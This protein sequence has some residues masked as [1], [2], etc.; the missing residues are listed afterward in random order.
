MR[1]ERCRR[2]KETAYAARVNYKPKPLGQTVPRSHRATTAVKSFR[3][4]SRLLLCLF[5]L[6]VALPCAVLAQTAA[7]APRTPEA[8]EALN[9][10]VTAAQQQD[11]MLAI[12]Y[13]QDARAI[14]PRDPLIILNLGL[15]ESKIPGRELRAIAWFG[16]Y[17]SA[18]PNASN[19]ATVTDQIGRLDAKN[20]SNLSR[21]IS[22]AQDAATSLSGSPQSEMLYKVAD[23]WAE[24]G[25]S[26]AALKTVDLMQD[27]R[28]KSPTEYRIAEIQVEDSDLA[29]A[30]KTADLIPDAR[31]K[32]AA[33]AAIA[34]AQAKA[35]DIAGARSTLAA[36]LQTADSIRALPNIGLPLLNIAK[37]QAAAGDTAGAQRTAVTI[38]DADLKSSAE[39]AIAGAQ[40]KAGDSAGA[41]S[42]L[43]S[44][45][46]TADSIQDPLAKTEAQA[47][48]AEAQAE[49]GDI[50][51]A[52]SALADALRIA[53]LIPD[54]YWKIAKQA[55]IAEAQ[56]RISSMQQAAARLGVS[57]WLNKLDDDNQSSDCA[58]NTRPFLDLTG[59]QTSLPRS[60]DPNDRV[61]A[62][63]G[64]AKALVKAQRVIDRMLK[65]QAQE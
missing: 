47:A 49:A 23:L 61:K 48:I 8:Q 15:A 25:Y 14:A 1:N 6:S 65:Q 32:S 4:Q 31:K 43:A 22:I 24:S 54:A 51:G 19:A 11:Y 20:H 50:A 21:L 55:D 2:K 27:V 40:A 5:S 28:F 45:V 26:A 60:D 37:A 63:A 64:E 18:N 38:Q 46:R 56:L 30:Q 42:T 59:Y 35:G 16:A 9:Q 36:A 57:D 7:P 39:A 17:L 53:D 41:R 62:L 58:L 44:A 12:R 29:G 34:E 13:F 33:Q 52:R 3:S 10:G